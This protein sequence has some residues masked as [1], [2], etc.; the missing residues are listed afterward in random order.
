MAYEDGPVQSLHMPLYFN[1][2]PFYN[3]DILGVCNSIECA[4]CSTIVGIVSVV[5]SVRFCFF[6]RICKGTKTVD[7]ILCP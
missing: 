5:I 4:M 3:N 7:D 6:R 1:E 2:Y